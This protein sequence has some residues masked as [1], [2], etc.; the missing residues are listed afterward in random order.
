MMSI[1]TKAWNSLNKSLRLWNSIA[2]ER[3]CS[4]T[5]K[6]ASVSHGPSC[7]LGPQLHFTFT[8]STS[9]MRVE[10]C[11]IFPTL[12]LPYLQK[13]L[14]I[15][16]GLERATAGDTNQCDGYL[17]PLKVEWWVSFCHQPAYLLTSTKPK[18]WK[19]GLHDNLVFDINKMKVHIPLTPTSHPLITCPTPAGN[20][21]LKSTPILFLRDGKEHD[22][23]RK[24]YLVWTRT[25]FH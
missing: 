16:T 21:P 10:F 24:K 1:E 13:E 14:Q 4:K 25:V 7:H 9:K 20:I 5:C 11:G 22:I 8:S 12:S 15:R 23:S 17:T 6:T 2:E 18:A 19:Y 3:R